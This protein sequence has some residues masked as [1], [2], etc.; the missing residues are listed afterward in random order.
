M[1]WVGTPISFK[2]W[3]IFQIRLLS[4][5]LPS[6]TRVLFRIEGGRVVLEVLDRRSLRSFIKILALPS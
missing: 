6:I 3:K 2:C 5:P 4:T 1:K